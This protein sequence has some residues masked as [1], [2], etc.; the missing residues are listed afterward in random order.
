VCVCVSERVCE[1][2]S[3]RERERECVCVC[4]VCVCVCAWVRVCAVCALRCVCCS[5]LC[6][7]PEREIPQTN[8]SN[9]HNIQSHKTTSSTTMHNTPLAL[10]WKALAHPFDTD[11][12][13]H[14]GGSKHTVRTG[15]KARS[16]VWQN[17]H[18]A[19]SLM[20]LDT[21]AV[22]TTSTQRQ[23]NT[24]E[25]NTSQHTYGQT[26]Q[27]MIGDMYGHKN[28]QHTHRPH[29]HNASPLPIPPHASNHIAHP[30]TTNT[31]KAC[32]PSTKLS[33][34]CLCSPT[35]SRARPTSSPPIPVHTT[36][37]Q[38]HLHTPISHSIHVFTSCTHDTA[39]PHT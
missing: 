22:S 4:A 9:P 13:S 27:D 17:Y 35:S 16:C 39:S 12:P 2:E 23:H 8:H 33:N 6:V 21:G 18:K 19:R 29:P 26:R 11:P 1:R 7:L 3:E 20:V 25:H 28:Q 31:N 30:H 37:L 5:V 36:P 34:A 38:L 14:L 15:Y 32:A 24:T 10:R